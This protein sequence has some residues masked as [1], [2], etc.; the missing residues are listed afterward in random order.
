M[1]AGI[2]VVF[3]LT[4]PGIDNAGH[5]GGVI[6]GFLLGLVVRPRWERSTATA[7]ATEPG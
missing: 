7:G 2:N 6:A 4:T 3:G 5:M 1:W